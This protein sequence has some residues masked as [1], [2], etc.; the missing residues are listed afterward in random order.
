MK[1]ITPDS[2]RKM[3]YELNKEMI[4]AAI[5]AVLDYAKKCVEEKRDL[6]QCVEEA[7]GNTPWILSHNER[8]M[9]AGFLYIMM[10]SH[11]PWIYE[12]FEEASNYWG[13]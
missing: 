5:S 1:M 12:Y 8:V 10:A 6:M 11:T 9:W 3:L 4:R 2:W 7:I 13:E